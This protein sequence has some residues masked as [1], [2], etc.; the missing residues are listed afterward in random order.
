MQTRADGEDGSWTVE[1]THV[2]CA[3]ESAV[4]CHAHAVLYHQGKC[5]G[6]GVIMLLTY[7][8]V[9]TV[10]GTQLSIDKDRR[11]QLPT[12]HY[13]ATCPHMHVQRCLSFLSVR[14]SSQTGQTCVCAM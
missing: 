12:A 11:R 13:S 7:F 8:V 10:Q 9:I 14:R 1:S 3:C 5:M 4:F 2:L 6:L